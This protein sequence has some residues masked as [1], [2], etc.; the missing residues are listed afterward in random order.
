M[1]VEYIGTYNGLELILQSWSVGVR[2]AK[3]L[4]SECGTT[5]NNTNYAKFYYQDIVDVYGNDFST[6]D[7]IHVSARYDEICVLSVDLNY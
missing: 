7:K 1:W 5:S 3:I 4:P 2:W 6:V